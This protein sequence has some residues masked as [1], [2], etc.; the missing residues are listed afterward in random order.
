[1]IEALVTSK[2]R[3]KLLLKFFLNS[4]SS[5]Y[6]RSLESE[7]GE[8]SNAI[9]V[10]LNRFEKAGLLMSFS[11]GNRKYYQA[12]K[13]HPLFPDIHNIIKKYIGL[14]QVINKIVNKLGHL[15]QVFLTGDYAEG[16]DNGI[17]DLIFVGENIDTS[18]LLHLIEKAEGLIK[19]KLR[20]MV[21]DGEE[22]GRY[23]RKMGGDGVVVLWESG[24]G[25]LERR[26]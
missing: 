25:S 2:T 8:S 26:A 6:L 15:E 10:E 17:I 7:F 13:T 20:Y 11:Q 21:M 4:N 14:D 3:V 18:Y 16:K 19:R 5:A 12:D 24:G 22:F 23:E 1:L 9:R